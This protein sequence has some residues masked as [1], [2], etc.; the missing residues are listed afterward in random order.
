MK[1]I[2]LFVL[3]VLL[4]S[5]AL[6][7]FSQKRIRKAPLEITGSALVNDI[8]AKNYAISVYLDGTK[9]D[10]LYT[11]SKKSINFYVNYNQVYTFL[12]EKEGCK[13]KI[14]IVNTNIPEGLK[15]MNEDVFEFE[16]EMSQSLAKNSDTEDYP[17]AVL[18]INKDEEM[19]EA[20]K[21]Y[22]AFTH[23]D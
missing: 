22:H 7:G 16:V 8:P 20:S 15:N 18:K 1:K 3:V 9:I 23:P 6:S 2:N 4:N 5:I 13:D 14:V 21:A 11:K 12:F 17:V 19:L 10:S